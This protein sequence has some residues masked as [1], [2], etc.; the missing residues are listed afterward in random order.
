[1][2]GVR[3]SAGPESETWPLD[4][5]S[6]FLTHHNDGLS[7]CALSV[8]PFSRCLLHLSPSFVCAGRVLSGVIPVGVRLFASRKLSQPRRNGD[9]AN[10]SVEHRRLRHVNESG[11]LPLTFSASGANDHSNVSKPVTSSCGLDQSPGVPPVYRKE[12]DTTF[13]NYDQTQANTPTDKVM[14]GKLTNVVSLSELRTDSR[15]PSPQTTHSHF[16]GQRKS[17][18]RKERREP[19]LSKPTSRESEPLPFF[20]QRPNRS[21]SQTEMAGNP[22]AL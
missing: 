12:G 7:P 18:K 9:G 14:H 22:S 17:E 11:E 2:G 15:R 1:V 5:C 3:G 6:V 20:G 19:N 10:M 8:G 4:D 21:I 13:E 16:L